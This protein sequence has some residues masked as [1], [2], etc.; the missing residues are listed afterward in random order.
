MLKGILH[1]VPNL[2]GIQGQAGEFFVSNRVDAHLLLTGLLWIYIFVIALGL[3][4]R[5]EV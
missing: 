2:H 1:I 4:K 3:F 5:K